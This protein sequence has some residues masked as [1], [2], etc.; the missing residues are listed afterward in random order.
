MLFR[1]IRRL[2]LG[3]G[4]EAS[5]RAA[6]LRLPDLALEP[7]EQSY[8][9]VGEHAYEYH[10]P[11]YTGLLEVDATGMIARYPGRWEREAGGTA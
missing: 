11:G 8:R 7:L 9:R 10:A 5:S 4:Q 1:S 2:G 6:W 3:L